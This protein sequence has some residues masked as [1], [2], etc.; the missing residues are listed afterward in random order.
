MTISIGA[1]FRHST[2][3]PRV[4]PG[5]EYW[6]SVAKQMS[7]KFPGSHP[8]VI[9]IVG[10]LAG[11]GTRLSFPGESTDPL[12]QHTPT[13][14]NESVFD[15]FDLN[16]VKVWL[17]VEPGFAEVSQ[18]LDEVLTRY[19]HHP[20]VAGAGVDVEWYQ[21]AE[22][23]SGKP[24]GDDEV[25]SWLATARKFNQGYRLFL[26][27]W[28]VEKIPVRI[29]EGLLF[30]DD[31]QEFPSLEGMLAEFR[32]WSQAF[33]PAPVGFQVGYPSD[34][35]WWGKYSDAPTE[36]GTALLKSFPSTAGLYW[37]DFSVLDVFPSDFVHPEN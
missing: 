12:I 15:L 20:C 25:A 35:N 37:V 9:W 2:Y 18:L 16:G 29:R 24:V 34:K 27:H 4:D 36:I 19:S 3:G 11:Q 28:L 17:Q 5:S 8:E 21:S 13:D 22:P 14:L 31:G 7:A 30:I 32:T 6:L 23:D 26:K 33:A 10:E 1:G